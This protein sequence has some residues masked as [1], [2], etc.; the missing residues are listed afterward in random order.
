MKKNKIWKPLTDELL[1]K[2][3]LTKEYV[4]RMIKQRK[5]YDGF[6][7]KK[8]AGVGRWMYFCEEDFIEFAGL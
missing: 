7:V 3:N 4:Y 1:A 6:V 5:W 8:I 2:Y